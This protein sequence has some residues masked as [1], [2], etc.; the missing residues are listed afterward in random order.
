MIS[1][2]SDREQYREELKN[3]AGLLAYTVPEKSLMSRY[4]SQERREAVAEQIN[5]AILSSCSQ[6]VVST[7]ELVTRQT[8]VAWAYANEHKAVLLPDA[9]I[10]PVKDFTPKKEGEVVPIFDL[11]TFLEARQ[12]TITTDISEPS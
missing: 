5:S 7:L 9:V 10:P 11:E 4:L 3:V 6:P 12:L 2:P 1:K 8:T